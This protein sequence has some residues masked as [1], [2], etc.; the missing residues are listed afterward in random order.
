MSSLYQQRLL[1]EFGGEDRFKQLWRRFRSASVQFAPCDLFHPADVKALISASPAKAPFF[2]YSNIFS[3]NFT[4][5]RFSREQAEE[6]YRHFKLSV[7][8]RFPKVIMYGA[9][10]SGR[11]H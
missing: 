7:T 1:R 4:L 3:T 9:D 8:T 6:S 10:V 11:W 5:A 2:Y